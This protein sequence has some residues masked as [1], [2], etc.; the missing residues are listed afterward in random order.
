MVFLLDLV[1]LL[2]AI[3]SKEASLPIFGEECV[4]VGLLHGEDHVL[5]VLS[6][7]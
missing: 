6:I 2:E 3:A 1:E 5:A 4:V 7:E